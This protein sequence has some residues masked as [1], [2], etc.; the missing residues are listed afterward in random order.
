M[1][2]FLALL[3]MIPLLL[4]MTVPPA[5]AKPLIDAS[6]AVMVDASTGQVIYEQ[7]AQKKLPI[8]SISK[9]LTAV[10]IEDEV[11][12]KQ[13]TGDT[14]VKIDSGVADI[15]NDPQYSAIGLQEGNAYTVRELLNASL[16]K[17]AD[18]AALALSAAAGDSLDEFNMKLQQ[19][20][21]DIGLKNYTIVNP[22]GLTNGDLKSLASKQYTDNAENAMTATDV[23]ILARYLVNHYPQLLQVTAQKQATFM[24]SKG[25]TKTEKNLNEMLPG[26][27]YTVP[28]VTI[29]GLKTGTSDKAGACFVSTGNYRGHRI[30]TVVLHANGQNKD[31]RF[32]QTQRLYQ[33][34]KQGDRLQTITLPKNIRQQPLADGQTRQATLSPKQITVWNAGGQIHKYTLAVKMKKQY[35]NK[36]GQLVAPLHRNQTLGELDLSSSQVKTLD[37]GPLTYRLTSTDNVARGNFW[38]RLWH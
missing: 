12:S 3:L 38:Q 8:A 32:V 25:K 34:L 2:K 23:A 31:N 4:G 27:K 22:V 20:A 16:V 11:H 33:M 36:Q 7:N 17:S 18:G 14:K 29:D 21:Q 10:V 26:G 28:G 6:A 37:G 13:I 35:L 19:K 15:S 9:L 30:I 5:H 1:K 24:I